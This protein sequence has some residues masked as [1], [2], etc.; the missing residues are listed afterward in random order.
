MVMTYRLTRRAA[1]LALILAAAACP[2]LAASPPP[3]PLSA[4]DQALVDRAVAYLQGLAG[5]KGHFIQT[6]ARQN[7]THGTFILQRPGKARFAYDAPTNLIM[8]SNGHLV[9]VW[10]Q[11]LKTFESYPLGMTPLS[12]FLAKEI[13]LDK[14][15]V[16]SRVEHLGDGFAI[17]A[18]DGKRQAQ[19]QITLTF[20]ANPVAL[21]G[22]TIT[23]AQGGATRVSLTDFS[24]A[25]PFEASLF[26]LKNPYP[27]TITR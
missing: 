15:V 10:N 8:A 1:A 16:V 3:V 5:A 17:V 24:P 14:G 25:G 6:D 22:W 19:G 12:V 27:R 9:S 11:R 13:R 26:D 23:D 7:V 4:D 20:S 2:A 21:T 18:R